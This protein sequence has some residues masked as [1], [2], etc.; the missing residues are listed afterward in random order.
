[1]SALSFVSTEVHREPP[2]GDAASIASV[3]DDV[4]IIKNS[5]S[6]INDLLRTMLDMQRA[7]SNRM[8]IE[9]GPT[10]LT[11]DVFEPVASML[12]HRGL[13]YEVFFDCCP[14]N[15]MVHTDRLRLTQ[16]VLNLARNSAKFV[17]AGYVRLQ[18]QVVDHGT[19]VQL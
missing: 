10:D 7:A 12:Y 4:G 5:H 11:K 17:N 9:K 15:L 18:A 3:R 6:F 13:N 16:V 19:N 8:K 2:L 14:A 1:M